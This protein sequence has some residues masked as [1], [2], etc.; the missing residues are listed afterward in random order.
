MYLTGILARCSDIEQRLA[1]L[2]RQLA[3]HVTGGDSARVWREL[4]LEDET[5]ADIL[6]REL[7]ELEDDDD[8]GSFFPEYVERLERADRALC[9]LE[10]R[11]WTMTTVDDATAFALAREQATV[12]DLYDDL[13]VKASPDFKLQTERLEAALTSSPAVN[14]P[15][16][17]RPRAT[18]RV[19]H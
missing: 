12:E 2:Y 7:R 15:G 11:A 3:A 10:E 1:R 14:V 13:V 19:G 8:S 18:R 9:E 4:A 17:P 5:H 16:L 6:R